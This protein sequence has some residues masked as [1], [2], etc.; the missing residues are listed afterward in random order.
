MIPV[1]K[2]SEDQKLIENAVEK[3]Q[4]HLFKWWEDLSETE[5]VQLLDQ[6]RTVD[7][8]FMA[9]LTAQIQEPEISI[10]MSRFSPPDIYPIPE[11]AEQKEREEKARNMGEEAIRQGRLGIFVVA[12]G[13]GSRL[14]FN[15]PKG[16]FPIG[17][18]SQ[19]PLFQIFAEKI[20]TA[21][22]K[23]N[24]T[25]PWYIMTSET[26]HEATRSFFQ[27]NNYFG[28]NPQDVYFFNQKMLPAVDE[29]GRLFLDDK[30]HLFMSPNG[31]GGSLLAL[32][33]SGALEDMNKRGIDILSYYQVDN[34]L[35]QLVDPVFIGYHLME[36]SQ[37]STKAIKRIDPHEKVGM[38]GMYD[39][40]LRVVEYSDMS[41]EDMTALNENGDLK[42]NAG[43]IGIH[44][45]NVQFIK[46]IASDGLKLPWHI[47]HKK[48]PYVN[49]E[50]KIIKPDT[51]NGYKF[52]TFVF[53][54]L[55]YA[56][57]TMIMQID[58]SIEFSP[59]KNATGKDSPETTQRDMC[60]LFGS[61]FESAGIPVP[62]DDDGNVQG[63]IEISP[64]FANS[65]EELAG[66]IL[67]DFIIKDPLYLE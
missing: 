51:P 43:S 34:P 21:S 6:L 38:L 14:G 20:Q 53:D 17:P 13:Q 29:A 8:D 16:A 58:K 18:V 23:F 19:K 40:R 64:L 11:T 60:Y 59:V 7:L 48:I 42:F 45:F 67:G 1:V 57:R 52:E 27:K 37:M 10:D 56:D 66:K 63:K 39:G 36:S 12:G 41:E 55:M 33:D 31:H 15:G 4:E 25:I 47:A 30:H 9:A 2:N 50:G 5:K 26:N 22:R 54:A 44:L 32:H 49:D 62:K 46:N 24:V 3:G 35:V 65:A 28:L 61:W